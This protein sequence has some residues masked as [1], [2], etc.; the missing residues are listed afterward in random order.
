MNGFIPQIQIR[1]EEADERD[2]RLRAPPSGGTRRGGAPDLGPDR[3][4]GH[5]RL[6]H[7]DVTT[8]DV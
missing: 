7:G 1:E 8:S 5:Q 2:E 3:A 6:R 4:D